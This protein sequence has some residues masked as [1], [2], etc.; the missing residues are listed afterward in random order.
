MDRVPPSHCVC[1]CVC[2]RAGV[3]Y[4]AVNH[5]ERLSDA[6]LNYRPW[7]TRSTNAKIYSKNNLMLWEWLQKSKVGELICQVRYT[8]PTVQMFSKTFTLTT[9]GAAAAHLV[10][11]SP[12]KTEKWIKFRFP[13][14]AESNGVEKYSSIASCVCEGNITIFKQHKNSVC[15][16]V[17]A[18]IWF[19]D[20]W[21]GLLVIEA[22]HD[23]SSQTHT[24]TQNRTEEFACRWYPINEKKNPLI[25][26]RLN[27]LVCLCFFSFDLYIVEEVLGFILSKRCFGML[28]WGSRIIFIGFCLL[29]MCVCVNVCSGNTTTT[30]TVVATTT[31]VAFNVSSYLCCSVWT[32]IVCFIY[33]VVY[34]YNFVWLSCSPDK[35]IVHKWCVRGARVSSYIHI[36]GT[37]ITNEEYLIISLY[38]V[39]SLVN[40]WRQNRTESE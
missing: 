37:E 32:A 39:E 26:H 21:F 23:R 30:T 16:C 15:L 20:D 24:H 31:A 18:A 13:L 11:S 10:L 34:S 8:T 4:Q 38:V 12:M 19:Y 6:N 1:L 17:S 2:V 5:T 7:V 40:K 28:S 27:R 22:I 9:S 36:N 33:T 25:D 14:T 35:S 3:Q 29:R